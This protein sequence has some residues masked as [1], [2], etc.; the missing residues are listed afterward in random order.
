MSHVVLIVC[1]DQV[2]TAICRF[3]LTS[4]EV[5]R[6]CLPCSNVPGAWD[7]PDSTNAY[8]HDAPIFL[9]ITIAVSPI[10]RS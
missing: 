2:Y 8:V 6:L 3:L 10:N 4:N 1:L 7:K 5:Q 9:E